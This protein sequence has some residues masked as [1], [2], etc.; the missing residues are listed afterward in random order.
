MKK[1]STFRCQ[2]CGKTEQ[3]ATLLPYDLIRPEITALIQKE[4]PGW[5]EHQFI[6]VDDL[7]RFRIDY[8]GSILE[9]ERGEISD[10][11]QEVITSLSKQEIFS[12]DVE[13]E[14]QA[15]RSVGEKVADHIAAAGG[16]WSFII[17]FMLF[18]VV[19]IGINTFLLLKKPFD[20]YPYILLNLFLSCIAA[21]Q[22]PIIM[23]SQKR[24]EARDRLQASHDYQINLKA[25]L[26]IR[27]LH[28]KI[29][30]LL[31]HQWQRLIEIQ[32]I[33]LELMKEIENQR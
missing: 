16:S 3:Q 15:K 22:A 10:L 30:H 23:M 24:Q 2:I 1:N 32:Q 18:L 27:H 29:D 9:T 7:N 17:I 11:E 5:S 31:S 19:W 12:H 6:C 33:Q 21:I 25:E 4:I 26:E 13:Q 28:R 14:F 20:P 8:I